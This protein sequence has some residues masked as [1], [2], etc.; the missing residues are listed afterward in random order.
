MYMFKSGS[1][2]TPLHF[3]PKKIHSAGNPLRRKSTPPE[4]HSGSKQKENTKR[5]YVILNHRL[6]KDGQAREA[7]L[8]MKNILKRCY[9]IFQA[10]IMTVTVMV[11]NLIFLLQEK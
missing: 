3:L 9:I 1:K 11:L 7:V 2:I 6:M 4:I 8:H 5:L 10:N